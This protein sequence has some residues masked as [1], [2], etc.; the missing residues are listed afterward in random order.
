MTPD[1][2]TDN[3][4]IATTR[5]WLEKAVI[6][7]NLCPFA[8]APYNRQQIRFAVSHARHLDAFL[9]TVDSELQLLAQTPASQLETT[10]LIE[11][12]LFNDFNDFNQLLELT[13]QA[14]IDQQLEGI[15]QIAP[16]HPHFQFAGTTAEDITNYTNRSPYPILHLIR[17]A[18]IDRAVR[19][20]N[21]DQL[22]ERNQQLL[23]DMDHDGW[24][25][26]NIEY[27]QKD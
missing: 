17:E 16:F 1:S 3:A 13:D 15:I 9:E 12:E 27:P 4:I 21:T 23:R 18:S 14:I 24:N 11:P 26:L 7:L 8:K 20:I 10:L 5:Y 6:G 19:A 2:A 25:S 22:I